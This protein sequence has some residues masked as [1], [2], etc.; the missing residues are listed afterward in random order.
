M[1]KPFNEKSNELIGS[2][3]CTECKGDII[4]IGYQKICQRCGLIVDEEFIQSSYKMFDNESIQFNQGKQYVSIGKTIEN[5]GTLGSYIDYYEK[6]GFFN[7]INGKSVSADMQAL[8][9]RLKNKYSKFSRIKNQETDYRIMNILSDVIQSMHLSQSI[10]KDAAYYYRKIKSLNKKIKN[11]I[12]L[13]AFCIFFSVRSR[14]HN[15]PVTIKEIAKIFQS[16][17]HRVN[18]RLIIRDGVF[19]KK[20]INP[21]KPHKSEDYI[22]RLI[23]SIISYP[24][25]EKRMKKKKSNLNLNEYR[26]KL[27]N[28]TISLLKEIKMPQRG[29]RNPFIF[30]GAAIYCADK[31]LAIKSKT[32]VILTQ[33][34][35]ALSMD[36]AEYSIRDHYVSIFKKILPNYLSNQEC[37]I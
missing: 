13:I 3:K 26:N 18:P 31:I 17:G 7:D 1:Y 19:Y 25:I 10:R 36:I 29:G 35:A 12:S 20:L 24:N 37:G 8:F 32:K 16:L 15:A 4:T 23:D 33:K 6:K 22:G 27:Y 9:S 2:I 28:E 21:P 5:I 11:N 30:A 34:I 14:N